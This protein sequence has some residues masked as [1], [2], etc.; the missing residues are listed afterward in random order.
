LNLELL[1]LFQKFNS[2]KNLFKVSRFKALKYFN[3][4]AVMGV[5]FVASNNVAYAQF[6]NQKNLSRTNLYLDIGALP[7]GQITI[8]MERRFYS[9]KRVTWY[10]RAGLGAGTSLGTE[11]VF[12]ALAAVTML[13]GKNRN[14]FEMNGGMAVGYAPSGEEVVGWPVFDLGY[15]Y[16]KPEGGFIFRAKLGTLGV[17]VSFGYSF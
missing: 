7:I 16:Q 1:I 2:M 13:T 14:H 9:G 10:G 15:R 8:N 11:G 5:F 12:G 4:A 3:V 6:E 17:G